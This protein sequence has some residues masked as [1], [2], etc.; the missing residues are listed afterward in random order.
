[1]ELSVL[2]DPS[3]SVELVLQGV[4]RGSMYAVMAV[5]LSLIFGILGIVNFAH[6]EFFMIGAYVMY[7]AV[8]VLALPIAVGLLAAALLLFVLGMLVE[9]VLIDPLRRR[10]G[11]G[12][13]L[14]SFVLTIGLTVVLQNLALELL[15]SQ[16]RGLSEMIAGS[17]DIFGVTLS[18]DRLFILSVAVAIVLSLWAAVRYTDIGK[19]VRATS[20]ASDAARTLGI[21]IRRVYT[22]TF[23][24]GAALA[25]VS[26][27]LL[28]TVFP[29]SPTVGML[30]VMKGFAVVVLGGLG[31]IPGAIV[32]GLIL[33]VVEA[34]AVFSFSSGWQHVIT[35]IL[36][37]VILIVRPQGIFTQQ[38]ERP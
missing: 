28:L 38:S 4:V 26:G 23:G 32:G 24:I 27:A 12:W 21:D 14:D 3:I 9:R 18:Y 33:G 6:G 11:R 10:S 19:S 37:I 16:R 5:G 7:F 25:G 29:A 15:G 34:F 2:L 13:L 1:M 31:N 17:I 35:A 36:V 30:P 22:L 8:S 20:Q